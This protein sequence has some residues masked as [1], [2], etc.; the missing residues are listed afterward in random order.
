MG[1]KDYGEDAMIWFMLNYLIDKQ[2]PEAIRQYA[3]YL[4]T[5]G[6]K[7]PG[8]ELK[9]IIADTTKLKKILSYETL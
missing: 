9:E 3:Q 8:G 7:I 6:K 1:C 2:D 5:G 4:E